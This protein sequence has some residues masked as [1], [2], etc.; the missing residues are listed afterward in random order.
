[1]SYT[2]MEGG[3]LMSDTN[4]NSRHDTQ[5]HVD[6]EIIS[7]PIPQFY[8][9]QTVPITPA[10]VGHSTMIRTKSMTSIVATRTMVRVHL[11]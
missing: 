7:S 4:P 5:G 11:L 9:N 10:T 8:R 1:M 3:P 6:Q 2:G